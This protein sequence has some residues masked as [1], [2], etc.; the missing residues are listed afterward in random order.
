M[1]RLEV[2]LVSFEFGEIVVSPS[3]VVLDSGGEVRR[4]L[5][6]VSLT[7]APTLSA[8]APLTLSPLP[9][10]EG[11]GGGQSPFLV[12]GI[13]AG[14]VVAAAG[15]LLLLFVLL[16]RALR[17]W[18]LPG[19][20]GATPEDVETEEPFERAEGLIDDDPVGAYRIIGQMVRRALTD[21]YQLP[22]ASMTTEELSSRLEPGGVDSWVVRLA[23]DL[24]SQCDAVVYAGYRPA[25]KR[26]RGDL[27]VAE[28]I[29]R[30]AD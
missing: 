3:V 18:S 14:A 19:P 4:S 21:A 6:S 28:E 30:V 2:L 8:A 22:V 20:E 7:I 23:T 24:L 5:S 17:G 25:P 12:P 29:L 1:H 13:V 27:V 9:A 10:V 26:R 16:R 15:L 11:I